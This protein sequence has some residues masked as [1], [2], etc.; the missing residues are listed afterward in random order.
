MAG[1]IDPARSIRDTCVDEREGGLGASLAR[2]FK[3]RPT[4]RVSPR[5]RVDSSSGVDKGISVRGRGAADCDL[6]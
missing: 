4:K 6:R 2:D 3:S 5:V 1:L